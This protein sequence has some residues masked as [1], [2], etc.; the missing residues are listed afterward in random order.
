MALLF[1]NE[2]EKHARG[3]HSVHG[4]A[5]TIRV[6]AHVQVCLFAIFESIY[7][8]T[9]YVRAPLWPNVDQSRAGSV[10]FA[11][12]IFAQVFLFAAIM[13]FHLEWYK[14]FDVG[15]RQST[16][17]STLRCRIFSLAT[18]VM[19]LA[20]ITF[21]AIELGMTSAEFMCASASEDYELYCQ[22]YTVLVGGVCTCSLY[23]GIALQRRFRG[24]A[25]Q[26]IQ[27][28]VMQACLVMAGLII[29]IA[30]RA[31]M[32]MGNF[33]CLFMILVLLKSGRSHLELLV[34]LPRFF[35]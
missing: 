15:T 34:P 1:P 13:T 17:T 2:I 30:L 29:F 7:S 5:Y 28:R 21:A 9:F 33:V 10:A 6:F 18:L 25:V 22:I 27:K 16:M 20:S 31:F 12:H 14:V 4:H 26:S 11:S 19:C 23:F 35:R 3:A 32:M 8:W 24:L